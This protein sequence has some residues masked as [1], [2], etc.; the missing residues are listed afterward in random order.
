MGKANVLALRGA[1]TIGMGVKGNTK[2]MASQNMN[3]EVMVQNWSGILS[4][5][6]TFLNDSRT[7]TFQE[8]CSPSQFWRASPLCRVF[9]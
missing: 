9:P 5:A 4:H 2:R 1:N 7:V 6:V 8:L 3:K